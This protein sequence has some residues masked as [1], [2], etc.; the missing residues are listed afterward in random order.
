M[1][2]QAGAEVNAASAVH[3]HTPLDIAMQLKQ[4]WQKDA[5]V[6]LLL[7]NGGQRTETEDVEAGKQG[8]GGEL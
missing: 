4:G 1:C 3:G 6:Q 5:I 2:Q 8:G 7:S